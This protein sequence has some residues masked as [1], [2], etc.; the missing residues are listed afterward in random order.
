MTATNPEGSAT[1]TS[2]PTA[3]VVGDGPVNTIAPAISGT[4]RRGVDADRGGRHLERRRQRLRATSGSA[5]PTAPPGSNIARRDERRRFELDHGRGRRDAA[6]A[7][8]RHQPGRRRQPRE[9][10]DRDRAGLAAR[11]HRPA[12]RHRRRAARPPRSAP[13]P[14][15]WTGPGN[16]L[17]ATSGSATAAPASPT[18]PARSRSPTSSPSRTSARRVRLRVTATNPDA[19][20]SAASLGTAR[21]A[22]RPA[23]RRRR[24]DDL[25]HGAPRRAAVLDA[26]ASWIGIEND[27]A[28]QWQRDTGSGYTD[29]AGATET[30]YLLVSADVGAQV[31]LQVTADQRRRHRQRRSA[32]RPAPSP[33]RRR[34]NLALPTIT[35]SPRRFATLTASRGE[36]TPE[37][38]LPVPVAARRRRHPQRQRLDLHAHGRRRRQARARRG[39]R[40]QRRRPPQRGLRPDGAGRAA[41]GEP[42]RAGR[43]DRDAAAGVHAHRRR[44]HLGRPGHDPRLHV[45]ALRADR[46]RD[47]RPLR[48][49]RRRHPVPALRRRHRRCGSAC[50][51]GRSPP[52]AR[53]SS[54]AR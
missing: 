32:P 48:R 17:R 52:A 39:H 15:T 10:R 40:D 25:R 4:A 37:A 51:C 43:A 26:W 12:D 49:R 42:R 50:A 36:W 46:H 11:Q 47:Q 34:R 53:R 18:S 8:H 3:V 21:R 45:G 23:R 31:R 29:I 1:A 30:T 20:V 5:R 22:G 33:P 16:T 13:P 27:Y 6:R 2:L 41:A 28:Y 24:P 9:R 14:G 38:D 19:T 44:R 54:T 7:R 35:G